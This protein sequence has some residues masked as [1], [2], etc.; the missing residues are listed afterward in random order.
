MI[1]RMIKPWIYLLAMVIS[2]GVAALSFSGVLFK[3]DATGRW[4]FGL[5]W[6][7]LAVVWM[8]QYVS[9]RKK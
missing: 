7:I 9:K 5:V 3:E 6:V 8:G 4:I 2:L 1:K